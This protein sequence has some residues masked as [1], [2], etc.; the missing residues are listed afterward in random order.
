MVGILALLIG[1]VAFTL[2][3]LT[4][5]RESLRF[6]EG[7][8][9]EQDE[10]EASV[11]V[12]SMPERATLYVDDEMVGKV[13]RLGVTVSLEPGMKHRL[14]LELDGYKPYSVTVSGQAGV[15][16]QVIAQLGA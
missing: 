15:A 3:H 9:I 4:R 2:H 16:D 10:N 11:F 13:S 7:F 6:T 12:L 14:R 5:D 8:Q 1:L